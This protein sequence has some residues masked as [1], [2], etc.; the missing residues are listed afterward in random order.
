LAVDEGWEADGA[1][2]EGGDDE[3]VGPG[4]DVA[5]EVLGMLVDVDIR[6]TGLRTRPR[7]R[8]VRDVESRMEP[9][10]SKMRRASMRV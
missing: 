3:G 6:G 10:K 2:A 5:A 7:T 1:D 8:K 9:R 4:E